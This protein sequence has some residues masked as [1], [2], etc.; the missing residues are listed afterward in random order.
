VIRVTQDR[1]LVRPLRPVKAWVKDV[2]GDD[3]ELQRLAMN[4][5]NPY[6]DP[7]SM[8][9]VVAIGALGL[10]QIAD[11]RALFTDIA[12]SGE[13][14]GFNTI[15]ARLRTVA[16]AKPDFVL[17][18]VIVFSPFVGQE[19]TVEGDEYIVLRAGDVLGVVEPTP[20]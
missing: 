7:V 13:W 16:P 4:L 6:S 8:G 18:D 9:A 11:V 19:F 1:V 15:R 3:P 20:A 2:A 17:G 14:L 12:E 5:A 10:V